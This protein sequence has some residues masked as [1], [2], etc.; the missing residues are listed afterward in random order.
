MD[1]DVVSFP[2]VLN[3]VCVHGSCVASMVFMGSFGVTYT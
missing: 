1:V 2:S 3:P